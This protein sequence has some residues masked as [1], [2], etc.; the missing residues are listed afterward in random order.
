VFH[1]VGKYDRVIRFTLA[2]VFLG[3]YFFK[4][5]PEA[6]TTYLLLGAG[7]MTMTA[8]RS[9]CPLYALLGMGTCSTQAEGRKDLP[10]IKPKKLKL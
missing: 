7:I 10:R 5:V 6:Y 2:L 3:L 1:N 4:V 9:C 8:V